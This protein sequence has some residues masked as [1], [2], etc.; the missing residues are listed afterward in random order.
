MYPCEV[1]E[2]AATAWREDGVLSKNFNLCIVMR[3]LG[4][5]RGAVGPWPHPMFKTYP[6]AARSKLF[7][8]RIGFGPECRGTKFPVL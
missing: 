4:G 1:T 2:Q 6:H 5:G 3:L 8:H 7:D